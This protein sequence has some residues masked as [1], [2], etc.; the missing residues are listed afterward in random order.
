MGIHMLLSIHWLVRIFIQS[1]GCRKYSPSRKNVELNTILT[2]R[3]Q[4]EHTPNPPGG[5]NFDSGQDSPGYRNS[6]VPKFYVFINQEKSMICDSFEMKQFIEAIKGLDR[7]SIIAAADQEAFEAWRYTKCHHDS[8]MLHRQIIISYEQGLK[9]LVALLRCNLF[10][11]GTYAE[12]FLSKDKAEAQ[13]KERE[14]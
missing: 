10:S 2:F 14:R 6:T 7:K 3:C 4:Y 5:F 13:E 9:N 11:E 1:I 8:D 12:R